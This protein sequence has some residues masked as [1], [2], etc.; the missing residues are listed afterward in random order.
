MTRLPSC[1]TFHLGAEG[2]L[3]VRLMHSSSNSNMLDRVLCACDALRSFCLVCAT[4]KC[5]LVSGVCHRE[6][7][8]V[9]VC[10]ERWAGLILE[11]EH[12][13]EK[14]WGRACHREVGSAWSA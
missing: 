4:G 6:G 12:A 11:C 13:T 14:K 7:F 3:G 10:T 8:L 1:L 2:G 5:A 9:S